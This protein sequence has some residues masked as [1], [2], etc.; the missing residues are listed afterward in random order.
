[1][2]YSASSLSSQFRSTERGVF[3]DTGFS[4]PCPELYPV[5]TGTVY[6]NQRYT[7]HDENERHRKADGN[8]CD[9]SSADTSTVMF[10][11]IS[12][13]KIPITQDRN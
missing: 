3:L 6:R 13:M 11:N 7:Y 1:M 9:D 10:D 2:G 5:Y 4:F 12:T 8:L